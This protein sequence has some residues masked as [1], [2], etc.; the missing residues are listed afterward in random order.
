MVATRAVRSAMVK[1]RAGAVDSWNGQIGRTG[2]GITTGPRGTTMTGKL[3]RPL[4]QA[5]MPNGIARAKVDIR[6]TLR[7][8]VDRMSTFARAIPFGIEA[9][10]N[11]LRSLPVIVVPLGPVVIPLPVLPIW[12][13]QLSTAPARDL[14]IA[15]RTARVATIAVAP[16]RL[17]G[18]IGETVT[19]VAMGKD[20]QGQP[21][22]GAK[23]QW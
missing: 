12:P 8:T 1:S 15:E 11:G 22:H 5:S 21:A 7:P 6:S 17:V 16:H 4:I 3:R 14:T 18:Y 13:F 2:S 10:I 19:F 23:F 20:I 9:C